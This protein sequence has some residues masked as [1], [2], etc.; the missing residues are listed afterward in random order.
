MILSIPSCVAKR[1]TFVGPEAPT[2]VIRRNH[3][4]DYTSRNA[5]MNATS[6]LV[7]CSNCPH[8]A[9]CSQL[10]E[11]LTSINARQGSSNGTPR[12]MTQEQAA[13]VL[14]ALKSGN[15]IARITSGKRRKAIVTASKYRT[16][17]QRYPDWAA[18]IRPLEV[19]NR[20]AADHLKG[21]PKRDRTHCP[22]GHLM[23]TTSKFWNGRRYRHCATCRKERDLRGVMPKPDVIKKVR[24]LL[25]EKH[26]I[27]SFTK[28]G[29]PGFLLSHRNLTHLRRARP[30][31]DVL[32]TETIKGSNFR[33]QAQRYAHQRFINGS[34][35]VQS[36]YYSEIVSMV[37]SF[38]RDRDDI[39]SDIFKALLDGSLRHDQVKARV[40]VFVTEQNRMFPTNFAKF[41]NSSLVSLDE[42]LFEDGSTTRGDTVSRSLWD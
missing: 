17:A 36:R 13:A 11:C 42:V 9:G 39:V 8:P 32:I 14:E 35:A 2:D 10:G 22:R 38:L 21:S 29:R 34:P 40:S 33:A 25:L 20:I 3:A 28:G 27:S 31:F 5:F 16:H 12:Y 7:P 19:A 30:E 18:T 26:S 24:A 37:P 41:G 6:Q 15:S 1:H 4:A 23:P